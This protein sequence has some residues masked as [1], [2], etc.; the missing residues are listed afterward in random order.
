[1]RK[2]ELSGGIVNDG[3]DDITITGRTFGSSRGGGEQN[4]SS[5]DARNANN[6]VQNSGTG[7]VT[8][9]NSKRSRTGGNR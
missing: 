1:M 5:A 6:D 8:I 2:E 3:A 7:K 4:I 9:N